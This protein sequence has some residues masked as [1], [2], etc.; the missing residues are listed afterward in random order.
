MIKK[1]K[2]FFKKKKEILKLKNS[3]SAKREILIN[4]KLTNIQHDLTIIKIQINNIVK[5]LREKK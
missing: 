3:E 4:Q 5:F 1:I 2:M